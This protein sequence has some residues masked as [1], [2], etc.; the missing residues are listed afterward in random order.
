MFYDFR[1]LYDRNFMA[2]NLAWAGQRGIHIF[3]FQEEAEC[4][5][6]RLSR[7]LGHDYILCIVDGLIGNN[8]GRPY[9]GAGVV[10]K[11]ERNLDNVPLPVHQ[12]L[13]QIS[14]SFEFQSSA[15]E[16]DDSATAIR[17]SSLSVD[18]ANFS[19]NS[20]V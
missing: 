20:Q 7:Y 5:I 18:A 12:T 14:S 11:R 2:P 16:S 15:R 17:V 1:L 10:A 8:Y 3:V 13:S 19:E 6:A 4:V 9:F